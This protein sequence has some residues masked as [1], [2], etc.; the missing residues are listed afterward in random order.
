MKE[1]TIEQKARAY[2][3]ALARA[4]KLQENSNR[5]ILKKWLRKWI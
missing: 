2:D 1:L 5:M 3:E 4:R